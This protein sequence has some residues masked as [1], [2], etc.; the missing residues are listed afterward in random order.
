MY[1]SRFAINKQTYLK[2][3]VLVSICESL[4]VQ[5]ATPVVQK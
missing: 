5:Q 4:V 3:V 1:I 2:K